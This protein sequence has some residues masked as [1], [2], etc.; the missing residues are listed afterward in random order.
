MLFVCIHSVSHAVGKNDKT[1]DT[2]RY[3]QV[4]R[5][6]KM[7][8]PAFDYPMIHRREIGFTKS[9]KAWV[10]LFD[11]VQHTSFDNHTETNSDTA[12]RIS[13]SRHLTV[14]S[15]EFSEYAKE[16]SHPLFFAPH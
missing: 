4:H 2:L 5:H 13:L 16:V 8:F 14:C 11:A 1:D 10:R 7:L 6:F 9:S 3:Y 12:F 15:P